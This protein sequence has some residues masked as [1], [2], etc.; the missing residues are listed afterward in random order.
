MGG[1]KKKKGEEKRLKKSKKKSNEWSALK[2][3]GKAPE[4]KGRNRVKDFFS[5]ACGLMARLVTSGQTCRGHEN[6]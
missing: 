5:K 3:S 2:F 1:E 6:F 4:R